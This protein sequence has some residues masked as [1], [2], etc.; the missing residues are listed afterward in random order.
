MDEVNKVP[1]EQTIE[2]I[3][4]EEKDVPENLGRNKPVSEIPAPKASIPKLIFIVGGLVAAIVVTVVLIIIGGGSNNQNSGGNLNENSH[5]HS[6]G[7]WS[8]VS[9]E[10][11]IADGKEERVC[12]C[13]EKESRTINAC[14]H[15]EVVDNAVDSTCTTTGLTEGKHCS[16]CKTIIVAQTPVEKIQHTYDDKYDENCNV[17]GYKRDAEC[18]HSETETINGYA[19]SCATT[20]LTDGTKCK[21]CGE[22]LTEQTTIPMSAHTNYS[23]PAV[24]ATCTQTGFTAGTKC[25]VCNKTLVA[26][27]ETPKT[28]HTYDDKYDETCNKC[29]FV[30]DAECAHREIET[31]NGYEATCTATGLTDG[32]KCK[33]CGEI[34][35]A[36][37]IVSLK[38]HTEVTDAAVAATC[39]A[40]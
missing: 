23:I 25:S 18:F 4:E 5:E 10:T 1:K 29:G 17:C 16:V 13:G 39:T 21:K 20:G 12:G 38:P 33:K 9:N 14:G 37:T 19:A 34:L 2:E 26:Q 22:I 36:Q 30:R 7:E 11:C 32:T 3:T 35:I 6:F 27:Q 40:T 8:V 24:D 15:K 28:A 31:I